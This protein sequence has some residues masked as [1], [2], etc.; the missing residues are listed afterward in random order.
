LGEGRYD[1]QNFG[2]FT[3]GADEI[4]WDWTQNISNYTTLRA[5]KTTAGQGKVWEIESSIAV[6]P[7]TINQGIRR[8]Y[9]P[10]QGLPAASGIP[11]DYVPVTNPDGSIAKSTIDVRDEDITT[12]WAGISSSSARITRVRADLAHAA[13]AADLVV[14]AAT[15][16][17]VLSNLRQTTKELNQPLCPVYTN[18]QVT[19]QAPR[20]VAASQS[21]GNRGNAAP[22]ASDRGSGGE[23]FTCGTSQQR[24]APAW[25]GG[26]L[27]ILALAELIRRRS[28]ARRT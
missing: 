24:P 18:C 17:S 10:G 3:I 16:Q 28:R 15:D 25:A 1:P 13:L 4:S 6:A 23:T 12:L 14:G 19:G 27:G 11:D 21:T 22:N 20:D 26:L 8:G 9:P 2:T 5:Q 7:E